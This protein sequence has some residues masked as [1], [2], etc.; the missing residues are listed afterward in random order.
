VH[1][2]LEERVDLRFRVLFEGTAQQPVAD[3][4]SRV[5]ERAY[6]Q[7]GKVLNSYPPEALT[8]LLYTDRQFQDITRAPAW[9]GGEFDGRIRVAVGGALRTPAALDRVMVHEFVH[10]AIASLAPRGV[11]VWV[12]EGLASMLES[13]DHSWVKTTLGGTRR[14]MTLEQLG[15]GFDRLGEEMV[16]VAYAES[17]IAGQLLIER[18]GPNLTLFLQM[19]GNG[20]TVDQALSTLDVGPEEFEAEW[21]RRIGAPVATTR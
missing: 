2:D 5:L 6:W 18:L 15:S 16:L 8:V 11:P 7:V 4:V 10:A 17:A 21:R 1:E 12:H 13:R 20:H 14:R 9:A 3:R 19:L